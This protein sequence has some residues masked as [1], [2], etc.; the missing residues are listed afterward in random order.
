M[1]ICLITSTVQTQTGSDGRFVFKNFYIT[2][3]CKRLDEWL[4]MTYNKEQHLTGKQM[5]ING[6]FC[7]MQEWILD[8]I[9]EYGYIIV[10]L[11]IMIENIFPPIPSEV[12]LTAGGFMTTI[13]NATMGVWGVII[14]ATIGSVLGAVILYSIGR[15][16]SPERLERILDGKMGKILRLKSEDVR[17]AQAWFDKRGKLT[18]FFCRFIPVIRSLISIPAGMTRMKI[19]VFLL[20]T[21]IG[22]FI[23]N[24]VLVMLGAAAGESWK[25][26]ADV[27]GVY[28]KVGV[29]VLGVLGVIA[30]TVFYLKRR[31]KDKVNTIKPKE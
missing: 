24:I 25:K 9:K 16:I 1:I 17:K 23:W 2:D 7:Y 8:S 14:S 18:V 28:S 19:P 26:I 3:I 13:E 29:I 12:I 4:L 6:G 15:L 30:V 27:M 31:N 20:L 22:T 21:T 10:L 11:L 5:R